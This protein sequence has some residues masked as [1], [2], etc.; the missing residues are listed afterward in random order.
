VVTTE[1]RVT[2][3]RRQR[4]RDGSV[5]LT[6][7]LPDTGV[8]VSVVG[9]FNGWNPHA[10]PL[11]K[12]TNGTRSVT[13]TL[14]EGTEVRFRYLDEFGTF[15]D[16]EDGEGFEPNGFGETHTLVVA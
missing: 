13:V 9:E 11:R 3:I 8:R 2:V 7:V 6:F 14:P 5:T 12:R 1:R 15:F 10:H 16:D 4:R